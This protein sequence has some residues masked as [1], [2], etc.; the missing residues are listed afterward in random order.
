M[1][2]DAEVQVRLRSMVE[3]GMAKCGLTLDH[4]N[5]MCIYAH[6]II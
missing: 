6:I 1:A 5:D 4:F 2:F 3:G